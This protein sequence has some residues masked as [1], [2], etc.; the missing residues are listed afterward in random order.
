MYACVVALRVDLQG[1]AVAQEAWYALPLVLISTV[2][3]VL[4]GFCYY[5]NFLFV[6]QVIACYFLQTR[7]VPRNRPLAF[8]GRHSFV[9]CIAPIIVIK[10]IMELAGW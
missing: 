5:F 9:I 10:I 3:F 7:L 6:L 8:V 4:L 1:L 2:P